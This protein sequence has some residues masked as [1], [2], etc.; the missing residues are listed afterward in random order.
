[1]N[2]ENGLT[3][4][5]RATNYATMRHIQR[6]Q[7]YL[8]RFARELLD[9]AERHDQ[10]KLAPPEVGLFTEFTPKLAGCTYGSP[11]YRGY[12]EAMSP[13]LA[14]HYARNR[15]HPEHWPRPD[16][17]E[18]K[19]LRGWIDRLK[20]IRDE[21]HQKAHGALSFAIDR[22]TKD[23]AALESP[24]NGMNLADVVEMFMDWKAATERHHDGN[25]RKSITQNR[26]RFGLSDQLA[27]ILGN[28][29]D[30]TEG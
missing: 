4:E 9:R 28:T 1:M 15:H 12:L 19:S 17:E 13:A 27:E 30:L 21:S 5:E 18:I 20:R 8:H 29:V 6:V 25:I 22:L 24:V 3:L 23:L 26:E 11:E 2:D 14:H 10:S 16:T 7:H